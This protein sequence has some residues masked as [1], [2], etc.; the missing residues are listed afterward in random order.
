MSFW[1]NQD[2]FLKIAEGQ[3]EGMRTFS[4]PGRRDG[5]SA[6]G[7][8][9]I[10]QIPSTAAIF[11]IPDPDGQQLEILSNNAADSSGGTGI[12]LFELEFLDS[13]GDEQ[14]EEILLNGTSPVATVSTD[15]DKIQ[16]MHGEE[17]GSNT[18]SEGNITLRQSTAVGTEVYEFIEAG[19]NQ[20]LS[21]RYN[22]PAGKTGYI[23]GWQV[24]AVTKVV[25]FRLRANVDRFD[26]TL[27]SAFN[28]QDAVIVDTTP[29]GWTPLPFL[30]C[31]AGA[32]IKVSGVSAA[33]GGDAGCQFDILL[34]D[35]DA[36]FNPRTVKL[37]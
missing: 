1:G 30:K 29:S 14:Q 15:I 8:A 25:D 36:K 19:G 24:S 27:Q 12:Q 32:Q 2:F 10:S 11:V 34:I 6:T 13:N 17:V 35:D 16:W 9:D 3:I 7:L 33:A 21:A 31:P 5:V 26:R 22:V 4:I 18:V 20:S 23:L 37:R 28:F